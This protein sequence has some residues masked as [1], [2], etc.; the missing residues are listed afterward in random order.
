[1]NKDTNPAIIVALFLLLDH[2]KLGIEEA[3]PRYIQE[4]MEEFDGL[5]FAEAWGKLDMKNHA[6]LLNWLEKWRVP[7]DPTFTDYHRREKVAARLLG[8]D[9]L[10]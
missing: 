7:F 3:H 9:G 6:R 1:M 2:H 5:T 10:V 4:K 8:I